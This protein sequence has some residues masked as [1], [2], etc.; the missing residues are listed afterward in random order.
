MLVIAYDYPKKK[1]GSAKT[2][3]PFEFQPAS[4]ARPWPHRFG[5][6]LFA[7]ASKALALSWTDLSEISALAQPC[8][9]RQ[10]KKQ[11]ACKA[12]SSFH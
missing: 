8:K 11:Q 7:T 1:G 6:I 4:N 5:E 9:T 10:P 3:P 2:E 12:D